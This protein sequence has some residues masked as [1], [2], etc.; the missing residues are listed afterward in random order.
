VA[1]LITRVVPGWRCIDGDRVAPQLL[2]RKHYPA[3]A[4]DSNQA[5][6]P[7]Q[8]DRGQRR[9]GRDSTRD[10]SEDEGG[11]HH[12]DTAGYQRQP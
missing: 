8:Q 9:R 3:R 11:L 1:L 2:D 4:D 12:T 5:D 6:Q 10:Q 7:V